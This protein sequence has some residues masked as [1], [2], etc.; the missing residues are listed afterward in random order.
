MEASAD[1]SPALYPH[2][3]GAR[4]LELDPAVRRAHGPG[5]AVRA[6]GS[7]TVRRGAGRLARLAGRALRLP[8]AGSDVEVRLEVATAGGEERWRRRFGDHPLDS[9]QRGS[10][11]GELIERFGALELRFGLVVSGGGL[12]WVQRGAG[13]RLGPARIPLPRWLSPHAAASEA[14][15]GGPDRTR[16]AVRVTLPLAGLLIAYEGTMRREGP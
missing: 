1:S 4:W 3:L 14:P 2:L 6:I 5:A 13:L 15:G 7:F 9:T 11:G 10:G 16:V 12:S 8:P